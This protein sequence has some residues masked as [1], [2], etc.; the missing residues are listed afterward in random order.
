MDNSSE[1]VIV[2]KEK[3]AY[4]NVTNLLPIKFN[5]ENES[6]DQSFDLVFNQ[7][8]LHHIADV[9]SILAKF[10]SMILPGGY[11]AIAD[12]FSED[13][14][15]HGEGFDGH[16]GFDPEKLKVQ[17]QEIGFKKVEFETCYSVV[18]KAEDGTTQSFPIFLITALK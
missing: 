8:V 12:L 3:V 13:G 11:L 10:Y 7:M 4:Q 9:K 15:F 6:F 5:L 14:S 1:M 17:L 18:R 2:M 16:L